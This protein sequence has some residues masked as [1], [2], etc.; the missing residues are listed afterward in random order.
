MLQGK[1]IAVTGAFG[2]LGAVVMQALAGAGAS[3]AGIAR[4]PVSKAPADSP[5]S[6]CLGTPTSATL[7]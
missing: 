3:V 7:E 2:A 4:A 6:P 1:R 5:A